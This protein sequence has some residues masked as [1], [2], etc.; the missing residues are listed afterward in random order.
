MLAPAGL[1]PPKWSASLLGPHP[2]EGERER[3]DGEDARRE[4]EEGRGRGR[5]EEGLLNKL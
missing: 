4:G 3:R 1:S 2:R 5:R